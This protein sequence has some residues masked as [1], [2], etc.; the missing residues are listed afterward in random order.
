MCQAYYLLED[1]LRRE[2]P[3]AVV[4]NVFAMQTGGAP[5]E[6]YNRLNI[7]GMRL[8]ASK[9]ASV[10]ASALEGESVLSYIFPI[11]RYHGRWSDLNA[12]D[13]IYFFNRDKVSVN[14]Y[15]MR[16]DVKPVGVIPAGK[17][18][19]DYRF[20]ET[21]YEYLD[22]MTKLC[23][24]NNIEFI[25]MK[26]PVIFPHWYAEWDE[27]ISEYAKANGLTYINCLDSAEDIGLDFAADTYN[28]GVN[29]NVYGAEKLSFYLGKILSDYTADRRSDSKY[30]AVWEEK[31]RVYNWLKTKQEREFE[32]QGKVSTFTIPKKIIYN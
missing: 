14:G 3:S 27:Q 21:N 11:F 25:L 9:I 10:K 4:F 30:S 29:L 23:K 15:M 31:I 19:P 24:D 18:L 26:A 6:E 17:R 7:D 12:D 13:F 20:G 16:C 28:A 1:T 8:S 22:K 2:K 32:E 5:K